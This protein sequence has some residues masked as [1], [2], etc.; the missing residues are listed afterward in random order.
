M[1]HR[2][3]AEELVELIKTTYEVSPEMAADFLR[4]LELS[5]KLKE[6]SD[7]ISIEVILNNPE[8]RS[9]RDVVLEEVREMISKCQ[10]KPLKLRNPGESPFE[11]LMQ[12]CVD[13]LDE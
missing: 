5:E 2:E 12:E 13:A 1:N 11:K 9:E 3:F 4:L 8:W 6:E 7:P 10:L